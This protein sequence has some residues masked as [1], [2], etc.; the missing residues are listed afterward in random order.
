MNS[1]ERML[2]ALARR[3][4][5]R[6]PRCEFG[7]DLALMRRILPPGT[8]QGRENDGQTACIDQNLFTIGEARAIADHLAL[9]NVS[10][11]LRAP[12]FDLDPSLP[13]HEGPLV[14]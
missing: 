14:A 13:E 12:V 8:L 2:T 5:D 6:V 7:I 4:P 10:Y 11:V 3:E 9:D 1:R